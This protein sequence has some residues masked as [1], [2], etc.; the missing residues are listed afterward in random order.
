MPLTTA[1]IRFP[2][3]LLGLPLTLTETLNQWIS[4]KDK[5]YFSKA[6]TMRMMNLAARMETPSTD[7]R[8]LYEFLCIPFD[9]E[10]IRLLEI[11]KAMYHAESAGRRYGVEAVLP[12]YRDP[13]S[14]T[15]AMLDRLEA[16][17]RLCDLCYNYARRFLNGA[18]GLLTGIQQRKDLIS[19]GII[20]VLSTQKLPGRK[21]RNCGHA[22]SWNWP[23]SLCDH[24]YGQ[25]Q[26]SVRYQR[27]R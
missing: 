19:S 3:S 21:C 10:D 11:W 23:Y 8:L 25:R 7:K 13:E 27:R 9:E 5:S 14:C 22:L 16:D 17:Y 1:V 24:C 2:E 12:E 15:V 18:D 6:S 20:H 4:M 26:Q